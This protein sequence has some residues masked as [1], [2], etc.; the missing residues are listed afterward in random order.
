[1]VGVQCDAAVA[2]K[3]TDEEAATAGEKYGYQAQVHK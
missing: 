1:M 2:E 3:P